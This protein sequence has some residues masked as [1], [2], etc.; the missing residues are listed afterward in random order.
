VASIKSAF[1]RDVTLCSLV[2]SDQCFGGTCYLHVKGS[3]AS[4]MFIPTYQSTWCLIPECTDCVVVIIIEAQNI[5]GI[6]PFLSF[7]ENNLV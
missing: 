3:G 1:F 2:D 4:R 7:A 6:H 5:L